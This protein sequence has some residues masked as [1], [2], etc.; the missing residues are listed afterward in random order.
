M[1][2]C[3]ED[4]ADILELESYA[5]RAAGFDVRR[6]ANGQ[7]AWGA[8]RCGAPDMLVLDVML[9]GMDGV[10]ILRRLRGSA[11][12]RDL[13][14]I[15]A[16]ARG[17]EADKVRSLDF[18]ADDYL[19]KPFGMIELVARV[20]AVLRRCGAAQRQLGMAG[21]LL[22]QAAH[23]VRLEGE[24]VALTYKEFR[25]LEHFL[26]HPGMAFSRE[27]LLAD[28]W[29]DDFQRET[30]TVDMHIRSLRRK[31]GDWG[32]CIETVRNIGY[33]LALRNVQEDI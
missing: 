18:G 8:L 11:A 31:L 14:V 24:C 32:H 12:W 13:P 29:G 33:R 5:L 30:R 9:P 23:S 25:L 3:V 2:W 6:F 21:L 19:V 4:D 17:G 22:D 28:I 20:K 26:A 16:T 15:M 7:D 10:E 27:Q 1:I